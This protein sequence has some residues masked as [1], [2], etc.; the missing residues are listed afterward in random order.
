MT[1]Q[2]RALLAIA[3]YIGLML[4]AG[5][6]VSE[7]VDRENLRRLVDSYGGLGILGF[8]LVEYVSV[9][10]APGYNTA[11]HIAAGYVFG[12]QLG[13]LLNMVATTAGLFTIIAI[14]K[15]W[16]RPLLLRIVSEKTLR[17]YDNA[18]DR[19]G[20]IALFL[21]YVAPFFPD[22][23]LTYLIAAG[24]APFRRYVLPVILGNIAKTSVSYIGDS[25]LQGLEMAVG[26]RIVVLVIG[27]VLI[28]AQEYVAV[29]RAKRT[30]H[31]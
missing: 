24:Q 6:G 8:L 23:E 12:G 26:S 28:G 2:R 7:F 27:L 20:P 30:P 17:Q 19:V 5:W 4:L 11:I 21:V 31:V 1:T 25:G 15:I 10:L 3:L 9:V 13:W 29:S 22:D 18:T 14:V 16:G